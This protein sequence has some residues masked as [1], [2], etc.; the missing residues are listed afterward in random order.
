MLGPWNTHRRSSA[1]VIALFGVLGVGCSEPSKSDGQ[2]RATQLASQLRGAFAEASLFE[3]LTRLTELT[4]KLDDDNLSAGR[5]VFD[6]YVAG[7]S[8]AEVR[9]F[10]SAWTRRDPVAALDYATAIPFSTQREEAIAVVIQEWAARDPAEARPRAEAPNADWSR[11]KIT[12]T[13]TASATLSISIRASYC[14]PWSMR[15]VR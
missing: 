15:C 5:D 1:I 12:N 8:D 2:L 10:M 11:R 4:E 7:L 14:S 6:E 3:R 13:S 9:I